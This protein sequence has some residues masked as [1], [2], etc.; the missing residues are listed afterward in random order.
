M[1]KDKPISPT[2]KIRQLEKRIEQLERDNALYK[3]LI[4]G[5]PLHIQI[6]NS[7]G[8]LILNNASEEI[9]YPPV[10]K[11]QNA[12]YNVLKDLKK[13][14]PEEAKKFEKAYR[15]ETY[16]QDIE[17]Y[18]D[19]EGETDQNMKAYRET[20][21][22]VKDKQGQVMYVFAVTEDISRVREE[23][24]AHEE[25]KEIF[26][27][28]YENAP[29]PF[30]SLDENGYFL[31]VNPAWQNTLGYKRKE[32]IGKSFVEF[33][34]PDWKPSFEKNFPEFKRRGTVH[35]VDFK[36]RHKK[37]HYLDVNFEGCIGYTPEG[38]V[39]QTYCVFKD[40]TVQKRVEE[41]LRKSEKKY[42]AIVENIND[43]MII[44]DMDGIITFV[45]DHACDLLGYGRKELLGMRLDVIHSRKMQPEILSLVNKKKWDD[46]NLVEQELL[47]KDGS[48][49]PVE[50]SSSI[51]SAGKT[52]EIHAYI[53]DISY[54]K[55][56][57]EAL[58]ESEEKF[59]SLFSSAPDAILLASTETG[60]IVDAN[61]AAANLFEKPIHDIIGMHQKELHPQTRRRQLQ[62]SFEQQREATE[63]NIAPVETTIITASGRE[64]EVEIRAKIISIQNNEFVL[65]IF[66][67]MT[68]RKKAENALRESERKLRELNVTKDKFFSIISHDLRNP[69]HTILGFSQLAL[70]KIR[71]KNYKDV[72]K[73][74]RQIYQSTRKS[75]SLLKNLLHWSKLQRGKIE[76]KPETILLEGLVEKVTGLVEINIK[77]KEQQLKMSVEPGLMVYADSFM[78]E[79]ILRN[80]LSNAIKYTSKKG[81]IKLTAFQTDNETKISVEDNGIGMK[82]EVIDRLF[83]IE[84]NHSTKGTDNEE[85][86][87]LG[88][89][90]CKEL[91]DQHGLQIDVE[92]EEGRGTV[93]TVTL[94]EKSSQH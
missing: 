48:L 53:R 15:G 59:F 18:S 40:V 54:R 88:L 49:I 45:N 70:E 22:P 25:T 60:N 72:E 87:G 92:S 61:R 85:G 65:G 21:F 9:L 23:K 80:L 39:K 12:T 46:S 75:Y 64:K 78:L 94:P 30:Q 33:L 56:V 44:H 55:G 51:V 93:F 57:E 26:R 2:D 89:I 34:H 47:S 50:V 68:Q 5:L 20:I 8:N 29:L 43:A 62:E 77:E 76:F 73:Y 7:D 63:F 37:G 84:E 13:K 1:R 36:L 3:N 32:V 31:E 69:F 35:N 14:N 79:T 67:D 58:K 4:E 74:C 11:K 66:R 71:K 83:K 27:N 10:V 86:T 82:P 28:F 41:E 6:Y 81:K 90:L 52:E 19:R 17:K 42:R 24:K 16:K 91:A 38:R